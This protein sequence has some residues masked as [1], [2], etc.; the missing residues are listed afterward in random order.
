MRAPPVD[1]FIEQDACATITRWSAAAAAL[2]GWP[3][4]EAIGMRSHMLVPERNRARHDTA[5]ETFLRS[6]AR[7]VQRQEF[8]AL[9]RDGHEFRAEFDISLEE[10][11]GMPFVAALARAITPDARTEAA[12]R[13]G[14]EQYRAILDQIQDGCCVV[15]LSKPIDQR[16]LYAIVE[17]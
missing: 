9:H 7:E 10:R 6:S 1:G 15:D 8:T 13:Q 2:F 5:L 16:S 4:A 12:F 3:E 11:G 17:D 14:G